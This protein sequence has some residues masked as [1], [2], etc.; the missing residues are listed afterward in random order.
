MCSTCQL[1][2]PSGEMALLT[3][4]Y[5]PR[6][7]PSSSRLPMFHVPPGAYLAR[8]RW[9]NVRQWVR[10]VRWVRW[11]R[12]VRR[13]PRVRWVR[14]VRWLRWEWWERRVRRVRWVEGAAGAATAAHHIITLGMPTIS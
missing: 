12:R 4:W 3:A 13:V 9:C 1:V 14:W 11:V 2:M 7:C 5:H 10:R 6:F 8:M